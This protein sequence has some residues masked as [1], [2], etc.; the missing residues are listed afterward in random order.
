[1]GRGQD[2]GLLGMFCLCG[3][4]P[5][6]MFNRERAHAFWSWDVS[7]CRGMLWC[8]VSDGVSQ[9]ITFR[10]LPPP[11]NRNAGIDLLLLVHV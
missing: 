6:C 7:V 1:M 9:K 3:Q 10:R 8:E 2:P 4:N 11:A 5:T